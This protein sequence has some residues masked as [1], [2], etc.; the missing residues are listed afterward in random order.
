MLSRL[1]IGY[2]L[3]IFYSCLI[4]IVLYEN[5]Y[6]S[7]TSCVYA[8]ILTLGLVKISMYERQI[9][10]EIQ[11]QKMDK[12]WKF[13]YQAADRPKKDHG[14]SGIRSGQSEPAEQTVWIDRTRTVRR[15]CMDRLQQADKSAR[16]SQSVT[17]NGCLP[18]SHTPHTKRSLLSIVSGRWSE[19][20]HRLSGSLLEVHQ[21]C[22]HLSISTF[23]GI[24]VIYST[25]WILGV[26]LSGLE[27]G[28]GFTNMIGGIASVTHCEC[29]AKIWTSLDGYFLSNR[30]LDGWG[31]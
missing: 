6:S 3:W 10:F 19:L 27:L 13:E 30:W 31:G 22:L 14:Q 1:F 29:C 11:N 16:G 24:C 7:N 21:L 15:P 5:L 2:F 23:H 9:K 28:S 4:W 18:L 25:L 12:V 26:F 20:G 17:F 8:C